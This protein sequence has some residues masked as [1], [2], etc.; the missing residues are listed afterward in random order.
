MLSRVYHDRF[1]FNSFYNIK[2]SHVRAGSSRRKDFTCCTVWVKREG[3]Q[4][5]A[6]GIPE[7]WVKNGMICVAK[8]T[9]VGI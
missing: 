2:R 9:Y 7:I 3:M 4:S 1:W 8:R 5:G 6:F